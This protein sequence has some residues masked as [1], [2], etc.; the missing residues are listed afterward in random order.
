[1]TNMT[2][3]I[4]DILTHALENISKES[5][6]SFKRKLSS[7]DVPPPYRKIPSSL[8][9]E[10]SAK[11]VV[12]CIISY[13]TIAEGQRITVQVLQ[14]INERQVSHDL[15]R[16]LQKETRVSRHAAA[17]T[18]DVTKRPGGAVSVPEEM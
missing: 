14:D 1:M 7:I 10:K 4:K 12:D 2:E 15:T 3:V 5:L 11:D 16:S 6:K 8:L 17:N 13:Y 9:D 18:G